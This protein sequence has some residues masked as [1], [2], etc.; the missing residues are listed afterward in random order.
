MSSLDNLVRLHRWVLD[1]K[2]QKLTELERLQERMNEDLTQLERELNKE[3]DA[4]Q[5]SFE[6][7]VAYPAYVSAVMER[8][9]KLR[10]S[11]AE[12]ASSI[13]A[14]RDE[15]SEAFQEFKKYELA[16]TNHD[17]RESQKRQRREQALLDEQGL[18]SH[19]RRAMEQA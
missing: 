12:L 2:R 14:A 3:A 6:G 11:I 8:R 13:E 9:K 16:K 1:E 10:N 4:A 17:K 15:V 5:T 7:T 19:R 18:Q